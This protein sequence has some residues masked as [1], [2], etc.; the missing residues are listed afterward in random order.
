MLAAVEDVCLSRATT[1]AIVCWSMTH[2]AGT[3][4]RG[5]AA[6]AADNDGT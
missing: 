6:A 1:T 2:W 5:A 3:G 4:L